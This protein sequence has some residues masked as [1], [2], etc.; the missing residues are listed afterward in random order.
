M[1]HQ[2]SLRECSGWFAA[3]AHWFSHDII[4]AL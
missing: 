4:I 2:L 3:K 1:A